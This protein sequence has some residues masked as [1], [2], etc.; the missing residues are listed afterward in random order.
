MT[1][2]RLSA[3]TKWNYPFSKKQRITKKCLEYILNK[4]K[5]TFC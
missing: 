1:T 5:V 2:V 3:G 4:T